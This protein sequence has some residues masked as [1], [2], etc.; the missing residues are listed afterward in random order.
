MSEN[1][2]YSPEKLDLEIFGELDEPNLDYEYNTLVVWKDK[3]GQLF[4]AQDSGCSCPTPFE[5]FEYTL[6]GEPPMDRITKGAS[7]EDFSHQVK[8]FEVPMSEK[9]ELIDKVERFLNKES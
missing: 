4:Y 6:G 9:M 2:Y 1:P 8:K 5:G 3:E 7:F